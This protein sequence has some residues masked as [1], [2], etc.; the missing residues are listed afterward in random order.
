M[1][2]FAKNLNLGK[3]VLPPDE[4]LAKQYHLNGS[5]TTESSK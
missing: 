1:G 3:C 2:N 5:S 4:S